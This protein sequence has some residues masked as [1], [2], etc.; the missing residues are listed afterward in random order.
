MSRKGSQSSDAF[1]RACELWDRGDAKRAYRVFHSLATR[2]DVGAQVNVGYFF[3]QGVGVRRNETKA[4]Y[5]YRRAYRRKDASAANNI[6]TIYRD[7]GATDRAIRWFR[8]AVALG[9]EGSLLEIAKL[10]LRAGTYRTRTLSYLKRVTRL[11]SVTE[12]DSEEAKKLLGNRTLNLE[13]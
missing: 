11:R 13:P 2:G 10:Y 8:R 6:G 4:L 7:R 12:A 9:D 3:D 1:S 5:W